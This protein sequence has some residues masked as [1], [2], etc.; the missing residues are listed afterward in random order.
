MAEL[1]QTLAYTYSDDYLK[2]NLGKYH[3][4]GPMRIEVA[5]KLVRCSPISDRMRLFKPRQATND[6]LVTFHDP[7]Y[8]KV[9]ES[10]ST[11]LEEAQNYGLGTMECPVFPELHTS[12]ST[13]VGG[14]LDATKRVVAEES[15]IEFPILAGMHHAHATRAEGFCYYN[16][17]VIALKYALKRG[18]KRILFL[19]T[20]VHHPNGVQEAFYSEPSILKIS[21][22]LS[23]KYIEPATGEIDEIGEGAGR[24]FNVNLPFY[25]STRDSAYLES[26]KKIVPPLWEA[27]NPELVI[28]ECG[29]DT[30]FADPIGELLLQTISFASLGQRVR[31]LS[32]ELP[33]GLVLA[34]GGGY[35]PEATARCWTVLLAGLLGV[36]LPEVCPTEWNEFVKLRFNIRSSETYHDARPLK[37]ADPDRAAI[38]KEKNDKY[39]ATLLETISP[40]F[41]F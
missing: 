30:H 12:A 22:H 31:E 26:F 16:D 15:R 9:V 7:K 13:I 19:D 36:T 25:P 35:N 2:Y 41:S 18:I 10:V 39:L 14:M 23:S 3:P 6:E 20:D 34:A 33:K 11:T 28:W 5:D 27:F 1:E 37:P 24:G 4:M 21:L 40:Y 38:V 32:E 29:T 8:V 17:I